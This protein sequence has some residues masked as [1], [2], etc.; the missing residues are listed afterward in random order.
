MTLQ[1]DALVDRRRLKRRLTLWRALAVVLAVGLVAAFVLRLETVATAVGYGSQVARVTVD[2]IIRD[3]REQQELLEKIAKAKHVKAVILRI[4]SPGGTTSGGESLYEAIKE[5]SEKKPV[6]AVF[7][8]VATSAAYMAA[9]A[10]DHIVARANTI[11]GSVGVIFQWAEV[12]K[13]MNTLGIKV[14]AV[15]SGPLKANPSPF[16][17]I[18]EAGRSLSEEMVSE[19]QTWFLDLVAEQRSIEPE[20]VPGLKEGRVFSGRQAHKLKLVDQ[21]GGEDAARDWLAKERKIDRDLPVVDWDK[22]DDGRLGLLG[23]AAKMLA[24]S[25]GLSPLALDSVAKSLAT[26]RSVQLDGLVSLWHPRHRR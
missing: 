16:E 2:G 7:G 17:P 21:I 5:V 25:L 26:I 1:A 22:T 12:T 24:R 10:S 6:V 19:A 15:R 9:L 8:T 14:E 4:N 3:D 20:D 18:D 23:G 13:L 11:T